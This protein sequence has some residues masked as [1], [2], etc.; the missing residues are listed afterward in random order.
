MAET[1]ALT[2]E[3][4]T[5]ESAADAMPMELPGHSTD[6][7]S[8]LGALD[9]L[10]FDN[11]T[12]IC[13]AGDLTTYQSFHICLQGA[14]ND[15]AAKL[16]VAK[17][18]NVVNAPLLFRAR[19]RGKFAASLAA[20]NAWY[21][22][23][24]TREGKAGGGGSSS[25]SSSSSTINTSD[26]SDDSVLGGGGD[27]N[28]SRE[29]KAGDSSSTID[30]SD[31]IDTSGTSGDS[32]GGGG[33]GGGGG[34]S[35]SSEGAPRSN[36]I[37]LVLDGAFPHG[38]MHLEDSNMYESYEV[39]SMLSVCPS[40]SP[41]PPH[42][43]ILFLVGDSDVNVCDGGC[44]CAG[45]EIITV[46]AVM[47]GG[48]TGTTAHRMLCFERPNG[49]A[50]ECPPKLATT[51]AA[52]CELVAAAIGVPTDHLGFVL[53]SI[54]LLS[55]PASRWEDIENAAAGRG[56][57]CEGHDFDNGTTAFAASYPSGVVESAWQQ[58]YM[59]TSPRGLMKVTR[60]QLRA[61]ITAVE[62]TDVGV[63]DDA[64]SGW[65]EQARATINAKEM[66]KRQAKRQAMKKRYPS[67]GG[68]DDDM[69]DPVPAISSGERGCRFEHGQV[70]SLIA[71]EN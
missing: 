14:G 56:T 44:W 55:R 16:R 5:M 67:W 42:P 27:V 24:K 66:K 37:K 46:W 30:A 12:E 2:V 18:R 50:D 19:L 71:P 70:F 59:S 68:D 52:T 9:V 57:F 10:T 22:A 69:G 43:R 49:E 32:V 6:N 51:T 54:M 33:G 13:L 36:A 58:P 62:C 15:E 38:C 31:N 28:S 34:D 11:L 60:A 26:V 39:V 47:K 40:P 29:G 41:G 53:R 25:S 1:A 63:L 17:L 48:G 20:L 35:S 61:T 8:K 3:M 23:E 4:D 45:N 21:Q 7:H 65:H 64:V